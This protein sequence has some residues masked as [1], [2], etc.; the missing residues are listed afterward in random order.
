MLWLV[1]NCTDADILDMEGL[2]TFAL[3][4]TGSA[5]CPEGFDHADL[6]NCLRARPTPRNPTVK[7]A[8]ATAIQG[9]PSEQTA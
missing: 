2:T 4:P 7:A 5:K 9:Q 1:L 3:G 6:R 8:D